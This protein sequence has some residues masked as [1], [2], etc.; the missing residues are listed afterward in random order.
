VVPG[1]TATDTVSGESEL[2]RWDMAT[3]KP[4][5]KPIHT[6]PSNLQGVV[7]SPD[8]NWFVTGGDYGPELYAADAKQSPVY[9]SHTNLVGR[10]VF[11][12]DNTMLLSV[13][14]DQTAPLWS[15]PDGQPF[16]PPI[17][18]MANV[19]ACAWSADVRYMVTAQYDGLIRVWQRPGDDFV[20]A[21][22]SG[23]GERPRVSFDGRLG[24]PGLWH[25]SSFDG[26]HNSVNRLRVVAA[27]SGQSAG[28]DISLPGA[29]VDSCVCADNLAVAA[30]FSSG[31][32]GQ[33]GV[34]DVAT[35]RARFHPITLPGLPLSVA[36]RP[37][38][39]ELAVICTTGDLLVFDDTTGKRVLELS[40]EA[41]TNSERSAQVLYAPDGKAIVSFCGGDSATFNVRD[42]DSGPL[43]FAPLR[44]SVAGSNF[45]SVSVSADSRLLATMALV[46]NAVQV[47]DL[48]TG[49]ALS[50]PLPHPGDFWGLFSVCFSPDGRYLLTAHKDGQVRYWDWQ[51]AKLVC[52]PMAHDDEVQN[53]AIT[54]D[55]RFAISAV[56]GRSKIQFW[57]SKTGRR[58]APPLRL[59]FI[60]RGS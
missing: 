52:P 20:I 19:E 47:W 54:P 25:E 46:K 39:G 49:R 12:R 40:H 4:V 8:G 23:W 33:L 15:V 9:L 34:W 16:G 42:A 51:A 53:V 17:R 60:E 29:L 14:W 2:T 21:K 32:N 27:L 10:F 57:A 22:E 26:R 24:V 55:G 56:S 35:A 41:W 1:P 36:A 13:S 38:S 37:G 59:S 44:S 30:V 28:A 58:V 3:G 43:R 48:A 45:H 31:G 6:K 18:H 5:T 7:A 11:S 50:E